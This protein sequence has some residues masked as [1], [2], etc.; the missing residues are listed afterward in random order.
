MGNLPVMLALAVTMVI[1]WLAMEFFASIG[2]W[3]SVRCTSSW[4]SLLLTIA[5]GYVGGTVLSCVST[6]V[7]LA[8]TLILYLG[9]GL[10]E[11]LF[12]FMNDAVIQFGGPGEIPYELTALFFAVG[13]AL[14]YWWA[15]RCADLRGRES[16][17]AHRTRADRSSCA[18]STW[19]ST[20]G[21]ELLRSQR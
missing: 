8:T 14:M 11:H 20:T 13:V 3:C 4:R 21:S 16:P 18:C 1:A 19:N 2:I 9:T 6:P 10:V 7:A 17:R 15:A 5:L 12:S